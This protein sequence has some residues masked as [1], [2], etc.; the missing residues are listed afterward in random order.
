MEKK[1]SF[2]GIVLC[3]HFFNCPMS[4]KCI[5]FYQRCDGYADCSSNEDELNCQI[6]RCNISTPS[7]RCSTNDRCITTDDLCNNITD[8]LYGEDEDDI[9]CG[10]YCEW[11][12]LNTCS[13][14]IEDT[15]QT[16]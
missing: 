7:F 10:H 12:S 4:K 1:I 5:P 13:S 2:N 3:R 15:I 8:C 14:K 9:I 16:K 11:P 6:L